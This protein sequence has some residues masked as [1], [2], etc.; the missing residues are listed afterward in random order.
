MVFGIPNVLFLFMLGGTISFATSLAQ[1]LFSH[2]EQ[3]KIWRKEIAEWNAELRKA[4]KEGDKKQL[5]KV[6]KKQQYIFQ[7]QGKM[8]WSSM[9]VSL[10]FI[11]PLLIMWQLLTGLLVTE[12]FIAFFPGV[13]P[14]IPIPIIGN[15]GPIFWWYLLAS[16]FSGTMFSHAFGL[17]TV[18]E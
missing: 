1:R 2:P 15:I 5:E 6:M 4:R 10:V 7:I 3:S 18:P 13:G 17:T 16:M 9:K 11:V 12:A 14:N 8:T